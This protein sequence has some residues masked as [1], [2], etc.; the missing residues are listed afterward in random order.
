MLLKVMSIAEITSD[1]IKEATIT[2]IAL[3]CSSFMV[4]HVTLCTNSSKASCK[5]NLNFMFKFYFFV[6]KVR[7]ELTVKPLPFFEFHPK[8]ASG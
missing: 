6:R 1:I 2:T 5:Y 7:F 8:T 4:G 3:P